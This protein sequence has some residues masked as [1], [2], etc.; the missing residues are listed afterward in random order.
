MNHRSENDLLQGAKNLDKQIL[1]EI[2]DI[3]S[4]AI[5]AYAYRILGEPQSAE[6]CV[7]ETFIRFLRGLQNNT[8][9][10]DNI[11]AYLY[12]VAHNWMTDQFRRK[13]AQIIELNENRDI[14]ADPSP[15]STLDE[16]MNLSKMRTAIQS[17][18]PEQRQAIV[19]RYVEGWEIQQVAEA[20]QRPSG[21]VRALLFRGLQSLRK[22]YAV[23]EVSDGTN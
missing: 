8:P 12:R 14:A 16:T 15:E 19:L 5:Y 7:S 22:M 20:M 2:Y 18:T 17:L 3:Y 4:P 13:T 10:R 23:Y 11:K 6:D 1:A 21:A 9:P